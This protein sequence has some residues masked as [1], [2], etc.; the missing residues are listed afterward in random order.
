MKFLK[1]NIG[2]YGIFLLSPFLAF[3]VAFRNFHLRESKYTVY[4]FIILFGFTFVLGNNALD[5]YRYAEYFKYSAT[6]SFSDFTESLSSLFLSEKTL[7]VSQQILS[8]TL[9]RIS[10]DHRILFGAVASIFGFF[11]I[12]SIDTVYRLYS[13]NKSHLALLFVLYFALIINPVFNINGF[14]F[15]TATW[16]FFFG[17]YNLIAFKNKK[18]ILFCLLSVFFHFSFIAPNLILITYLLLGNRNKLY[19]IFF[20]ASFF[21]S[22]VILQLFPQVI[23]YFGEGIAAKSGRYTSIAHLEKI[24]EH[25]EWAKEQSK[26]YLYLPGKILFYYIV[27]SFL[28]I[29]YKYKQYIISN[30]IRN[31][32][33]FSLLLLAFANSVSFIPSMWRFNTL[34]YLFG[35]TCIISLL[36]ASK[37]KNIKWLF[38][39]GLLPFSL[40][41]IVILRLGFDVL[42][43]WLF[44]LLP[45]PFIFDSTSVYQFLF[46]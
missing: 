4:F 24:A 19:F 31:L 12:K 7:D 22:D 36:T 8:F 9:S 32:Y 10:D 45:F 13:Q 42:N 18:H 46:N 6:L 15:W 5:S 14:R 16:I 30:Q 44:T 23:S 35:L 29:S 38:I 39:V 34:F 17:T 26:W 41:T 37:A 40:N 43:P 3:I 25:A 21:I 20:L 28:F 27:S 33:S 11:Y 1:Q 2:L